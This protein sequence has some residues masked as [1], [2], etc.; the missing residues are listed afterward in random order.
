M[1]LRYIVILR[2]E[3][4]NKLFINGTPYILEMRRA[5]P[6]PENPSLS[7]G[8]TWAQG[9]DFYTNLGARTASGPFF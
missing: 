8:P 4:N 1:K 6:E 3:R 7:A 2:T 5:Q 9:R